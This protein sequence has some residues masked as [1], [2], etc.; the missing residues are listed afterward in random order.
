MS[1]F[2]ITKETAISV[3][4]SP[5]GLSAILSQRKHG[6]SNSQILA[7]PSRSL[8]PTEQRYSQAEKEV[9][10][11]VWGIEHF[12]FYIYGAPFVLHT[13]YKPLKLIY[14]NPVSK[15]P[16]RIERWMSRLQEYDF[17]ALYKSS[18]ENPADFLSLYLPA[19]T[20]KARNRAEGYVIFLVYT[21][22]P[23]SITLQEADFLSR[24][25]PVYTA[26]ARYAQLF[27]LVTGILTVFKVTNRSD[28]R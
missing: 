14:A 15:N 6:S 25:L 11:I 17:K 20:A 23:Q 27:P 7:Y 22:V 8:S 4:A 10:A 26:K 1:Y 24:Y 13:D 19:Y 28:T 21:A 5:V 2:D 12:H 3:D 9:L 16:A 18:A